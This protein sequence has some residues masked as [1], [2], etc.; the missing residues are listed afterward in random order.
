MDEK[1]A[2]SLIDRWSDDYFKFNIDIV[3]CIDLTSNMKSIIDKVKETV[4]TLHKDFQKA[5]EDR[6][7][8]SIN[9]LRIKVIGFRNF[10]C[11]GD[12]AL[13]Q[14]S[15]FRLP[16][17]TEL[18]ESYVNNLEAKGGGGLFAN[19]L[20][21]LALAIKSDWHISKNRNKQVII[22][23]TNSIAHP[24]EK[25]AEN[26]KKNYPKGMPSSYPELVDWWYGAK[27]Y[28]NQYTK[29]LFVCAPEGSK[30][31]ESIEEDFDSCL[32]NYIEH[33]KGDEDNTTAVLIKALFFDSMA[34]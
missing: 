33:C 28:I 24:L 1:N 19:S 10:Y 30:P 2:E 20:E 7:L 18:F 31:W 17:E 3:C 6:F 21:A 25:A 14:S 23:F 9:Q 29:F 12:Q 27:H 11:D 26:A 15:F 32:F 8:S 22:L 16:D 13:E 34:G 4:L 5:L